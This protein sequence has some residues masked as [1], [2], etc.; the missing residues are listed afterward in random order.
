MGRHVDD[1]ET[2]DTD[3]GDS[4]EQRVSKRRDLAR[5]RGHREH[6]HH[7]RDGDQKER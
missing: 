3:C 6:Q 7:R 2:R 1:R 4:G 5:S